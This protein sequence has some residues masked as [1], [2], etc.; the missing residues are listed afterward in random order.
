MVCKKSIN[1]QDNIERHI[2]PGVDPK[3][4][5]I[6]L[7]EIEDVGCYI[8]KYTRENRPLGEYNNNLR[9]MC[10]GAPYR[11]GKP[12]AFRRIH[13]ALHDSL[14]QGRKIRLTILENV[15]DAALR[16]EREQYWIEKLGANLNSLPNQTIMFGSK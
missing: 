5:G 10:A 3:K 7:W 11:K 6:Y 4:P 13:H 15:T 2:K 16:N 12:T 9:K 8:G 14:H 1:L